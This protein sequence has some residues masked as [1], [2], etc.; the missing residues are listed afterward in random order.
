MDLQTRSANF[1][2]CGDTIEDTLSGQVC[3]F[4]PRYSPDLNCSLTLFS[5]PGTRLSLTVN[6][7]DLSYSNVNTCVGGN[8]L[9]ILGSNTEGAMSLLLSFPHGLCGNV[10]PSQPIETTDNQLFLILRSVHS[11]AA[12]SFCLSYTAFKTIPGKCK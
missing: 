4:I 5:P 1:T 6:E 12:S 2:G 11:V 7:V 10:K 3:S 8:R 9:E